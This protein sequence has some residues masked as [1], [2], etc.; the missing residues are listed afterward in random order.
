MAAMPKEG[1]A[2]IKINKLL[3]A[4]G[5]RFFDDG[6]GKANVA[7]EPNVK[8]TQAQ[9]DAMGNDFETSSK[10]FID[11]L[12]LDDQ[13]FP[14]LVL[15]AKA[16]NKNPLIGKEQARKYAKSQNCRFV[17]LSNGNLHYLWDVQHG[18]PHVL[19]RFPAPSAIKGY[20][21]FQPDPKRLVAEDLPPDY[22][23]R[24][25]MPAY[26]Q[27]AGWKNPDEC[28]AFTQ[29]NRLRFMRLYQQRAAHAIQTA[30]KDGKTRFLL[31][32]ATGCLTTWP[33]GRSLLFVSPLENYPCHFMQS[34][35][36]L[37]IDRKPYPTDRKV[38]YCRR[39]LFHLWPKVLSR[40]SEE[41]P[42]SPIRCLNF[43]SSRRRIHGTNEKPP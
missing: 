13:G 21:R 26:D 15:E 5:W 40:Q 37:E 36:F 42:F 18:N 12:L 33:R 14:L 3:E 34:L 35:S 27:E 10:G 20:A 19:T 2:R 4:A 43:A 22:I 17:I 7:L 24:T 41:R 8:L 31:E 9:V 38:S 11:F 1:H 6:P 29:K 30:V 25:Q 28:A 39:S 16:E 23:A 32:M